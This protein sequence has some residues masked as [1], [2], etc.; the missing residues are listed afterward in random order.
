MSISYEDVRRWNADGVETAATGLR[1]RRDK[2]IGLQDELDGA[3]ALPDWRG[4]AAD[5]ARQSLGTTR[6]NAE[7][8]VAELSAVVMA[9]ENASDDVT[10]LRSKVTNNDS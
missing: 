5:T 1:G 7:I 6:N 2:L 3:R 8:L 4:A 10:T 9:L